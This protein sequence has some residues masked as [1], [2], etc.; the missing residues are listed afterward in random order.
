VTDSRAAAVEEN[1]I[2]LCRLFADS[3]VVTRLPDADVIAY[4]SDVAFPLFNAIAGAR[5]AAGTEADRTA[6]LVD[7]YRARGL[8]FLWWAT[9]SHLTPAMDAVIRSRGIEPEAD[10]GMHVPLDG[11]VDEALVAG[12]TLDE[13]G[14]TAE[15]V[16]TMVAGFGFPA[17]VVA[18]PLT[19]ALASLAPDVAFHVV[20]RVDGEPVGVGSGFLTGRTLGLYNIAT[21][22]VARRRG[23]GYAVTARLMNL[24]RERGCTEAVLIASAMGRPTYERLGFVEV[25][26]T[27][28][29]VW[30]PEGG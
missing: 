18:E 5:F 23:V 21:L 8:P 22:E 2:A 20:A 11:P 14:V 7:A 25:C 26:Q 13:S 3:G 9:P 28:Q 10:P 12:L 16:E 29:Y 27:P 24:G 6:A 1:L 19:R 15:V 17:E 30:V 4:T